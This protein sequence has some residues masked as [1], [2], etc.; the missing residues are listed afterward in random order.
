MP[1]RSVTSKHSASPRRVA[2]AAKATAT[3]PG[4]TTSPEPKCGPRAAGVGLHPGR[5][6]ADGI[7]EVARRLLAGQPVVLALVSVGAY[8]PAIRTE[9]TPAFVVLSL[10]GS[11]LAYAHDP[12]EAACLA[13]RLSGLDDAAKSERAELVHAPLVQPLDAVLAARATLARAESTE[14]E[15]NRLTQADYWLRERRG[16][17]AAWE[18][19]HRLASRWTALDLAN[20][21]APGHATASTTTTNTTLN[22]PTA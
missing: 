16:N 10:Q 2:R 7:G 8:T 4:A 19:L 22:H 5:V 20:H 1:K 14:R 17:P 18:P 6:D 13:L 11:P 21:R 3:T 12:F 9:V 15:W